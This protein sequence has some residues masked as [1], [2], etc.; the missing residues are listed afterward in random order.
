MEP[1]LLFRPAVIAMPESCLTRGCHS[2]RRKLITLSPPGAPG[3]QPLR[4]ANVPLIRRDHIAATI[5]V[6]TASVLTDD[7]QAIRI[8]PTRPRTH[9]QRLL[10][11]FVDEIS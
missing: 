5:D 10:A 7:S 11:L 6:E 4:F 8:R 3:K 1:K 2:S 9:R